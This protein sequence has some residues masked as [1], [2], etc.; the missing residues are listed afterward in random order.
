MEMAELRRGVDMS[1]SIDER[2]PDAAP[3]TLRIFRCATPEVTDRSA[4]DLAARFGLPAGRYGETRYTADKVTYAEGQHE[5]TVYRGS[6]GV[7]YRDRAR[8][9]VDHGGDLDLA[10]DDAVDLARSFVEEYELAPLAECRLDKVT[11]LRVGLADRAATVS[12]E[13]VIDVGVIFRR[14]IDGVAADG[15]GGH[16][17]IYIGADRRMTGADRIW[18]RIAGV[19]RDVEA[20]QPREWLEE[21]LRRRYGADTGTRLD[22]RQ[23]RLGYF[24][25]GWRIEQEYIQPAYVVLAGLRSADERIHSRTVY[26]APAATNHVGEII[27]L[28]KE[29]RPQPARAE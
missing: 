17:L 10:D 8:W 21:R 19:E 16:V 11:R 9:Q 1:E 26:A 7:R 15:P 6:G 5:I 25:H 22:V 2:W 13:R 24:E 23:I 18:R 12:E 29:I 4:A 27:P 20:L 28:E 14:I 3:T